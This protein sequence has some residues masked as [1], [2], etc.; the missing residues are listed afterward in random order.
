MRVSG[1]SPS[2]K[3]RNLIIN[4]EVIEGNDVLS[5]FHAA[6]LPAL[7]PSKQKTMVS[8]ERDKICK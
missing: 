3:M 2:G 7:S 5:A 4:P 1:S 6:S 8:A